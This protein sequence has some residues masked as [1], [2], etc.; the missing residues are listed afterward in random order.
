MS[1]R[2]QSIP[3]LQGRA[4][5]SALLDVLEPITNNVDIITGR[6]VGKLAKVSA[7]PTNAE[8]AAALNALIDRLQE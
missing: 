5:P 1:Q 3:A 6:K 7:N 2:T 8:L 4:I